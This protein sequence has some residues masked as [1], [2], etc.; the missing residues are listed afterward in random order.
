[1]QPRQRPQ[2]PQQKISNQTDL[3]NPMAAMEMVLSRSRVG[4][5]KV[6]QKRTGNGAHKIIHGAPL[7]S[8]PLVILIIVLAIL[9]AWIGSWV[10][11]YRRF[12]VFR[13]FANVLECSVI[14]FS[15]A[16]ID[17]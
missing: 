9:N 4:R 10:V 17:G 6:M 13:Q 7:S 2:R 16:D 5:D 3:R 8:A 14:T 12:S 15:L 1:M 11:V